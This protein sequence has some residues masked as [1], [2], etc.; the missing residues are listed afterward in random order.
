MSKKTQGWYAIDVKKSMDIYKMTE[1]ELR[2]RMQ[3][4]LDA[5]VPLRMSV[6]DF[7]A[8]K[9]AAFGPFATK[10]HA[11]SMPPTELN[12]EDQDLFGNAWD[13]VTFQL[14]DDL[15]VVPN[16]KLLQ[17][18]YICLDPN[19]RAIQT[20]QGGCQECRFDPERKDNFTKTTL[21]RKWDSE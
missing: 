20:F 11:L 16:F 21:Y 14:P 5:K 10:K 7:L 13:F 3:Q 19:C 17:K 6:F 1:S 12:E 2:A 9:N 15:I 8:G 4:D 18:R